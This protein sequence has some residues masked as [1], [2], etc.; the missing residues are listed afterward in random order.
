[1]AY[2][3]YMEVNNGTTQLQPKRT[4]T[5][6]EFYEGTNTSGDGIGSILG[7]N[8]TN[9]RLLWI[10][11]TQSTLNATNTILRFS[12]GGT[13]STSAI[14]AIATDGATRQNLNIGGAFIAN[15][16]TYG[17]INKNLKFHNIQVADDVAFM[18]DLIKELLQVVFLL[19]IILFH[20]FGGCLYL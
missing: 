2:L 4:S 11:D 15:S 6:Q 8:R 13:N 3:L 10:G 14:D 19:V 1:M 7:V 20:R 5:A 12:V 16:T 18:N 9:N 17:S